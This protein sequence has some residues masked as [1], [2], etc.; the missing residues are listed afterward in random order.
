M[1]EAQ[2]RGQMESSMKRL[3]EANKQ[4]KRA[5]KQKLRQ[6]AS[7]GAT[8]SVGHGAFW[9][10]EASGLESESLNG[11]ERHEL[12]R[13]LRVRRTIRRTLITS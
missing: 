7:K 11:G 4:Q 9:M 12:M 8:S 10:E 5:V 2:L 13:F 1:A 6:E 3:S